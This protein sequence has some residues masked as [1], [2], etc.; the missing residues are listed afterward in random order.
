MII[1]ENITNEDPIIIEARL[2]TE[3]IGPKQRTESK[4]M[5]YRR[6][7]K[8]SCEEMAMYATVHESLNN[9]IKV[10]SCNIF[11]ILKFGFRKN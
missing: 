8:L 7:G 1:A 2:Q 6:I 10:Q 9:F 11:S 4:F 5:A 3:K